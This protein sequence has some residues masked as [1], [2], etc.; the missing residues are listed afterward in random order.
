MSTVESASPSCVSHYEWVDTHTLELAL[1]TNR[2]R[3][4]FLEDGLIRC[5]YVSGAVFENIPSYGV[6][7]EYKSHPVKVQE[8]EDE[9]AY[10]L[11]AGR[12]LL[13]VRKSDGGLEFHEATT[14]REL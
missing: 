14:G 13:R 6:S 11:R 12:V 8:R 7:R 4:Y 5:R 9:A 10:E 2:L 3:L 1:P